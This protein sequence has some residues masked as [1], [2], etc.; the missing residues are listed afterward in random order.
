[1][2]NA[3]RYRREPLGKRVVKEFEAVAVSDAPPDDLK[4]MA[5]GAATS[6]PKG[7]NTD[8]FC[9]SIEPLNRKRKRL[10]SG[11]LNFDT[12]SVM[13]GDL[14]VGKYLSLDMCWSVGRGIRWNGCETHNGVVVYVAAEGGFGIRT[15]IKALRVHRG[16]AKF[17]LVPCPIDL[18]SGKADAN[19]LIALIREVE[20]E[21]GEACVLLV[22]DTLS[23]AMAGGDENSSTDMAQFVANVD[24]IRDATKSHV[25]CDSPHG[26]G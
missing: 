4:T 2:A 8:Q 26:Q 17:A 21:F 14:N 16:D 18:R 24:R 6:K 7:F 10:I 23:R 1:M 9:P 22:I 20:T 11:W 3:Y 25:L 19:A 13:Y 15:R 5:T 12:V